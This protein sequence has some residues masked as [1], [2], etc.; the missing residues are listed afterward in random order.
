M[1]WVQHA[2]IPAHT[3]TPPMRQVT[4]ALP[5]TLVPLLDPQAPM[6]SEPPLM[7]TRNE[8]D[9]KQGD[10]WRCDQCERLWRVGDACDACDWYGDSPHPGM[11]TLGLVWRPATLWQRLRYRRR[12]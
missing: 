10:L 2:T 8:V 4:Y 9:G 5:V 11:C 6:Q 7:H 1:T 12:H 3:C